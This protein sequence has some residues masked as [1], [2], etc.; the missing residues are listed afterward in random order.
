MDATERGG[1]FLTDIKN[2]VPIGFPY[3][4]VAFLF[5]CE[6]INNKIHKKD[7]KHKSSFQFSYGLS[8]SSFSSFLRGFSQSFVAPI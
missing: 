8:Y 3:I 7:E 5:L 1:Q 4:P 2:V 6:E